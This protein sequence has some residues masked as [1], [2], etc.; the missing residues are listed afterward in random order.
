MWEGRAMSGGQM[1][2]AR[3]NLLLTTN[4]LKTTLGLSLT[5]KEKELETKHGAVNGSHATE[6]PSLDHTTSN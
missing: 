3:Q 4:L 5:A 6:I 2:K 1:S